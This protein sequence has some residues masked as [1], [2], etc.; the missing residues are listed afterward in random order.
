MLVR[1]MMRPLTLIAVL[2]IL[3]LVNANRFALAEPK[4]KSSEDSLE[5]AWAVTIKE[6][7]GTPQLPSWYKALVT[8]SSGGGLVA[9][10][11]D[12]LLKSGHGAWIQTE[13][14]KFAVTILLF[15]FDPI[16]NFLGTLKARATLKLHGN[17][18]T[19]DSDDYQFEF[20]DPDGNPTG[21]VGVG[22]AHGTRIAVE[23][24]L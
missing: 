3:T 23:R 17:S 19:F 12:P 15:Q 11:T 18:D 1:K 4:S 14:R 5:G 24:L 10:I 20:F 21:F 16:G 8:F 13:K 6:G 2:S 9:T 22:T 7:A